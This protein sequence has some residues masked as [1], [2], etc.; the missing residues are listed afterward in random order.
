MDKPIDQLTSQEIVDLMIEDLQ[1]NTGFLIELEKFNKKM[2]RKNKL[3][4]DKFDR[5]YNQYE[6][7][8][9]LEKEGKLEEA[10]ALHVDNLKNIP[11][12]SVYY[13]RPCIVLDKLGRY[14]E[15]IQIC[16]LAIEQI[17]ANKFNADL[18]SFMRRKERLERKKS[19]ADK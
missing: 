8:V 10:L 4:A 13:E 11:E 5:I 14:D 2:A 9:S 15:A 17:K 12:G 6:K 1:H 19:K 7:A 16:E 3:E 18:S